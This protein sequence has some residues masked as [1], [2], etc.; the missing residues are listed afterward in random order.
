LAGAQPAYRVR[1][2]NTTQ[3]TESGADPQGMVAVGDRVF[4]KGSDVA[5]GAEPWTSDGTAAGTF[6]LRDIMPGFVTSDMR[7]AVAAD[8]LVYFLASELDAGV[9]IWRSDGTSAGTFRFVDLPGTVSPFALAKVGPTLFFSALDFATGT[10][11]G[12][13]LWKTD[14]TPAGTTLVRDIVPGSDSSYPRDFRVVGGTLFFVAFNP[15]SADFQL[16][17]SDGTE[18]GTVPLGMAPP[19]LDVREPTAVGSTVFF[20]ARSFGQD[21]E[22][23][24]SDGTDAGTQ[25]VLDIEPGPDGSYPE[26]LTA[27]GGQLFFVAGTALTGR[28]LWKSNGTAAGTTLVADSAPGAGTIEPRDL[29]ALGARVF[30][31]GQTAAE[32]RELWTSD[33]TAAGTRLV[34]D[35]WP[36]PSLAFPPSELTS[37]GGSL[38]F[39]AEDPDHGRELWKSDGTSSGTVLVSDLR[40]GPDPSF[41]H[42]LTTGASA[43]FFGG[44]SDGFHSLLWRTN[45][46]AAG[47]V[48]VN[49]PGPGLYSSYPEALG[50]AGDALAF[51]IR[52]SSSAGLWLSDGTEGGTVL[53]APPCAP[54]VSADSPSASA[55]GLRFFPGED[56]AHGTELWVSDGTPAGTHM[57]ADLAPGPS[58]SSIQSLTA[59]G[60]RVFMSTTTGSTPR[61]WTVT[62]TQP[63]AFVANVMAD[64]AV[65]FKGELFFVNAIGLWRS[66]G[67]AA[68]TVPV[69]PSVT[70]TTLMAT[71]TTLYFTKLD[72]FTGEELWKTDG[73][74]AGTRIV[75]DICPGFCSSVSNFGDDV[76]YAVLG[77]T[78]YFVADDG[79]HGR[80]L[81]RTDGTPAG[82]TLVSDILPGLLPSN[83]LSLVE[84]GGALLMTA[85][86]GASGR[87]LWRSDGTPAGTARVADIAPGPSSGAFFATLNRAGGEVFFAA[88]RLLDGLELWKSDGTGA[89]TVRVGDIAP[90]PSSSSPQR[91]AAAGPRVFF[92]AND[93]STGTELWAVDVRPS[94]SVTGAVVAEGDAG[95]TNAVFEVGLTGDL[96]QPATVNY[97]TVGGSAVS[98]VDF[99]PTA[100]TLTFGPG[101][102]S[103]P[104]AVAVNG[105]LAQ[106]AD[107]SFR[108]QLFGATGVAVDGGSASGVILDD[109][110]P[111][112]A[113]AD[114][115]VAE[116]DAGTVNA[117]FAVTLSTADGGLTT[118]ET[119]VAFQAGE[120]TA[121]SPTDFTAATGSLTFPAGSSSG[122]VSILSVGVNGDTTDEPD[123]TFRV[124]LTAQTA[125]VLADGSARGVIRDDDGSPGAD[126]NGLGHG[127]VVHGDLAAQ[128]GPAP[129]IDW[130]H[131]PA[132]AP[133]SYEVIVDEVSGDL[134]PLAVDLL[135][136]SGTQI[137]TQSVPLGTGGARSLRFYQADDDQKIRVRS[138]ACTTEC[139]SADTYRIRAY[140]TSYAIPRYNSAGG[141]V[142]FVILQNRTSEPVSVTVWF[143]NDAGGSAGQADRDLEPRAS[144]VIPAPSDTAGS[145][146]VVHNGGYGALAGKSVTLDPVLG[147][148]YDA[149]MEPRRR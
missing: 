146:T 66:D 106:E 103:L 17:R 50:E 99:M 102:A 43:L 27:V 123:E 125:A 1:D 5:N 87:E 132:A 121:S 141:L 143:W 137:A 129:D 56:A 69:A 19:P 36:G 109:D 128:P 91:F 119:V 57:V 67:T 16:W 118:S 60:G 54:C 11:T 26:R 15:A 49:P 94:L 145:V 65:A 76:P 130:Y 144:V 29:T 47:T 120:V 9:Q 136:A 116:G 63:P 95:T 70:S 139:T 149:V 3:A 113:I 90:G 34:R 51:T 111:S 24:K 42:D 89:G 73:T 10:G 20:S 82:T 135:F 6:V 97:A 48:V 39:A 45:G 32:G 142:S 40:P 147:A 140:D 107:E 79:V 44:S 21:Q 46:T 85:T 83:P 117:S 22:L 61:L 108:L 138:G 131:F 14:G 72:A 114:Q 35:I 75:L 80:E 126:L 101:T 68:G 88:H 104:V 31:T 110:Q 30:Y 41:P 77:E 52:P 92:A 37:F 122:A 115:V 7:Q 8:G 78:L 112:L 133:S 134:Q 58:H 2:I 93:G 38:Y 62:G 127:S 4:F 74:A 148:S 64:P 25:R 124:D 53:G 105:D 84:L 18:A 71:P 81:W 13:E 28:E 86:D 96:T 59:V 33:G 100:G 12:I 98:G 55:G 23:W